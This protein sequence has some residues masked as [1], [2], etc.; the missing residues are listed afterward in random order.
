M[1]VEFSTPV[2]RLVW[3]NPTRPTVKKD[4]QT[5]QPIIRNGK[6]VEQWVFGV[7]FSKAEFE[8]SVLPY[9]Q[10]EAASAF[11][12]GTPANFS[13]KFKDGDGV[14]PK[15]VSYA[16]REGHAGCY[17]LTVSTESFAP[18]VFKFD[19]GSYR[20]ITPEEIRTGDYV[21]LSLTVKF[22]G[23]T[24]THTPG[25]YINP[26]GVNHVGY[27]EEITSVSADPTTLFGTQ[28]AQLPPGASATPVAAA[29]PMPTAQPV[30]VAPQAQPVQTAQ[31]AP[32]PMAAPA[33]GFVQQ[34]GMPAP[35]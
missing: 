22:N 35:R 21:Q 1:T 32:Q 30:Q 7:A 6:E 9:L 23:A 20:Q 10:Q 18:P 4:Q 16:Q 27:G 5:K 13:W 26:V 19:N 33:T 3:G 34:A 12:N 2:G 17:I 28:P 8:Q 24:G 14:D 25:L 31:P 15:G 29:A 11:P